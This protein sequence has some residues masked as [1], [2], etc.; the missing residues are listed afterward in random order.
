MAP[1]SR[2]VRVKTVCTTSASANTAAV[3]SRWRSV[4]PSERS[5]TSPPSRYG[6]VIDAITATALTATSTAKA[7][8]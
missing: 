8:R 7:L 6:P 5:S 4:T 1:R 2:I 3:R